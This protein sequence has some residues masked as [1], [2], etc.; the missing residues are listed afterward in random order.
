MEKEQEKQKE[1]QPL[2]GI[3]VPL[4]RQSDRKPSASFT[5][6]F[7]TFNITMLWFLLSIFEGFGSVK[8]RPFD[9]SGASML[10][11]I[12]FSLYFSRRYTDQKGNILKTRDQ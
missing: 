6:M 12:V 10:L 11:G 9:F 5:V 4:L 8:I 7:V 1:I 3:P 2:K